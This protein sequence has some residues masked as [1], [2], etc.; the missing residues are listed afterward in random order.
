MIDKSEWQK[1]NRELIAEE[2]RN[3]GDPP[4]AEEMLAYS[5]GKLS[6]SEEERIRDLLVAYPELARMYSEP[7]PEAPRLGDADYVPDSQVAAGWNELQ[8][9]LGAPQKRERQRGNV[10]LFSYFPT[11]V[12][13]IFAL[14]FF[15]LF[16]HAESR[17]R[18]HAEQANLPRILGS[19]QELDPDGNRGSGAPTML[20]KDGEAYLLKPRLINQVRHPHYRIE[21]RDANDAPIWTNNTA[22]PDQDDTFQIVI[23][24]AFLRT[25]ETYELRVIGVDGNTHTTIG[26][27]DLAVP[28]E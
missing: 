27:Y 11:G 5:R 19:P 18:Y 26:S 1:A 2:R 22:Q 28:A 25:G 3:L 7:F 17:A 24:H 13:A 10:R 14:V 23:P 21:L 6:E 15:G 4:T 12:A 8:Q 9:R 20:R 16:V